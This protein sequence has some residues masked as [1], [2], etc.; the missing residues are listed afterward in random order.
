LEPID[1]LYLIPIILMS[2][3]VISA[4]VQ[5]K[6]NAI[7]GLVGIVAGLIV[8]ILAGPYYWYSIITIRNYWIYDAGFS[9]LLVASVLHL[10]SVWFMMFVA[11]INLYMTGGYTLWT[12]VLPRGISFKD[13]RKLTRDMRRD[14]GGLI[15]AIIGGGMILGTVLAGWGIYNFFQ[16]PD[17]TY[18]IDSPIG[19]SSSWLPFSAGGLG[20]NTDLIILLFGGVV[21]VWMLFRAQKSD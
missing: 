2:M 6:L 15:G 11:G 16:N 17:V 20:I 8:T 7:I 3:F 10:L 13:I 18:N 21:I 19:G 9:W 4:V 14:E 1:L 12:M 5:K